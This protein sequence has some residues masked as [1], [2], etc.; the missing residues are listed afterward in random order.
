MKDSWKNRHSYDLYPKESI[1]N[2]KNKKLNYQISKR[3]LFLIGS[4][5]PIESV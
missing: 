4:I 1:R 2:L 3:N 5:L